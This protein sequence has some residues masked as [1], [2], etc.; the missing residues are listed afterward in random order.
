MMRKATRLAACVIT[1]GAGVSC[2]S[3]AAA[4]AVPTIPAPPIRSPLDGNSVNL[5]NGQFEVS[6]P[7][8]VIGQPGAGGLSHVRHRVATGWRHDYFLTVTTTST[9]ATVSVGGQ[10]A[11]FTLSG[12]SY[13]ADKGDGETL[14][15]T[16]AAYTYTM[17]DGTI[18]TFDRSM[19]TSNSSYYGN[20]AAVGTVIQSPSGER[21][22]LTYTGGSY[23]M[24][25]PPYGV[26][27]ISVLRLHSVTNNSGFELKYDYGS[28][29]ANN[30]TEWT[31]IAK[32]TAINNSVDYCSPATCPAFTQTWPSVAYST[33]VS[34]S[35][36]QESVTDALGRVT[37]YTTNSSQKLVGIKRPSSS[38]DNTIIS[39]DANGRVSSVSNGAVNW[40]YAWSLSGT[41]LTATIT[42]PLSHQRVTT[43][44]TSQLNLLTD[45]DALNHMTSYQYDGSGRLTRVTAP[46]GNYIQYVYDA[47]GNRVASAA[48]AKV[49]SGL[50]V[51]SSSAGYD[52]ACSNPRTCNKPNTSVDPRGNITNYTYDPTHGGLL[53]VTA[54]ADASGTRPQTRYSYTPLYAYYKNSSGTIVAAP[55]PIYKLTGVSS[56]AIGSSCVGTA[57]E[58]KAAI[59]YGAP[60]VANN[61]LPT[62]VTS[63]SGDGTLTA[64]TTTGY[65]MVGN[66]SVVDGPLPGTA[67]TTNFK[68]DAARQLIMAV[69]PDPDGAG[70]LKNRAVQTAYNLD[71]QPTTASQGTSN[72]DGSGFVNLR[73]KT[74]SY[75]TLGR[76]ATESITSGGTT[77]AVVQYSYDAAN[78]L[79]CTA[80]RMNPTVFAALPASACTMGASGGF[81]Q[82]RIAKNSYD[83]ADR[84]TSVIT[85]YGSGV[86]RTDQT[87]GYSNNDRLVTL[88][89]GRNN[90]TTYEYDGF[91]RLSKTRYPSPTT[92]GTS[93]TTDFEQ[94]SYDAASNV[95]IRRLRDGQIIGYGYDSLNRLTSK[96]LPSPEYDVSYAYDLLGRTTQVSRPGDGVTLATTYDALGRLLT[97]SQA[98]GSTTSQYDLA[99]RRTRLTWND[100]FYVTYDYLNTG[101]MIAVRE[102]GATSGAG[103]LATYGYDDLG[104]RT[105]L[106]RGNG[107]ITT[108]NYDP[109]SRLSTLSQDLAGTSADQIQTFPSY[110][111]GGQI[112]S[113]TRSNDAYAW[114][115]AVN[116]NRPYT[117]NGLNQYT[118]TGAI[119]PT[120]DARGNLTSAGGSTYSY[121]SENLLKAATGATSATLY[122]D[123]VGRLSEFD[124]ASST[125][126]LYDGS[127]MIA[128]LAN[129]SG[130]VLRRYVHGPAV[131]EPLVWYEGSGVTDRRWLHADER[132]SVT[133]IS[134][135][136]GSSIAIDSYDEY[137]IPQSTNIGRFQYTGQAWLPELG[138]Y[139]YKARIYSATLG[140]FLQTD[141]I[142]YS[143]GMNLHVYAQNDP[144]NTKDP[145]GLEGNS[146]PIGAYENAS[147]N[148]AEIFVTARLTESIGRLVDIDWTPQNNVNL[149]NSLPTYSINPN[150]QKETSQK[151]K[152]GHQYRQNN[153][154]C[155]KP[156]NGQQRADIL[157]RAAVPG[158]EGELM[159]N[160]TYLAAPYG[161]P[162]GYVNTRFSADYNQVVNVT[163]SFHAFSGSVTRTIY[164]NSSGTFIETIGVGNAGSGII[165]GIRDSINQV[166][167]PQIFNDVDSTAGAYAQRNI[168]G[169]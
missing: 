11:T 126:F 29:F 6:V 116:L 152:K 112:M 102:N 158:H 127:T 31:R 160:G 104:Q 155:A 40:G 27:N 111:P 62:S 98:F 110:N 129:P 100:G 146:I 57:S 73:Q 16:T 90:L 91:D 20:V 130:S 19:I 9:S 156:L 123:P 48:I 14:T 86:Q 137:G 88:A 124:A 109:V 128:E 77:Y 26:I 70:A 108:Y 166:T 82:D 169:C 34:G 105:N 97:E 5:A 3:I 74:V 35:N 75:D 39:Y 18:V 53:S 136:S 135:G 36:T 163:T 139:Y 96:D 85:G 122:Y 52:T 45:R 15:A 165:G 41:T 17:R 89:D 159:S 49:G 133:A 92:A 131:D 69:S 164:S 103:V 113:Q 95:T 114:T 79:D 25:I 150:F 118:L 83:V 148:V 138:L 87:M 94:L 22:S 44:S 78:R 68:Y 141:P 168:P 154:V 71:G 161:F 157:R 143:D 93:S 76:K 147:E 30:I 80:Q 42:D 33:A 125:R 37:R 120:Y 21:T 64:S 32:V 72:S 119:T 12:G 144:V 142:G 7:E 28:E 99:G 65:D 2:V 46:E 1:L 38:S 55:V 121:T 54:P 101:E 145:S 151:P 56:C 117:A 60:G 47:R 58:V 106:T 132:G 162:G 67:D 24:P 134:N 8:L 140:R 153:K 115:Q 81:G 51:I 10:S 59:I 107:A 84:L 61:L 13:T 4:Q 63:G 167:G 66:R 50:P 23:S 43:A 149:L